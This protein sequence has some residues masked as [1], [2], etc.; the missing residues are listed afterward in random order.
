MKRRST[1]TPE[2]YLTG[3]TVALSC[4]VRLFQHH[5]AYWISRHVN[6]K[7]TFLRVEKCDE[8]V[9][10]LSARQMEDVFMSRDEICS[11][12]TTTTVEQFV[13]YLQ[14]RRSTY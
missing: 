4:A 8:G 10:F 6:N 14:L 9:V 1:E 5:A 13:C 2:P 7:G 11:L 12:L 3:H